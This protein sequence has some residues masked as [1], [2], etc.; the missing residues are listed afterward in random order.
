MKW[1]GEQVKVMRRAK[2]S[3]HAADVKNVIR[4]Y[5]IEVSAENIGDLDEVSFSCVKLC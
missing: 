3:V 4:S 2:V 1:I 5:S